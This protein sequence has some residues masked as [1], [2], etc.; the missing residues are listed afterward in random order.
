M[1]ALIISNFSFEYHTFLHHSQTFALTGF[2]VDVFEYHTFLHHSQT[3]AHT[4][5]LFY[6]LSTIHFYII[7]KQFI[8]PVIL[9]RVWVPYIFTSFSNA[10]VCSASSSSFE[11]HTF[12]HHSQTQLL[13][14][15]R[16][17][18]FEY[19]TFLHHSQTGHGNGTLCIRLS[20]IHF[21]IILKHILRTYT[22]LLRLSTIHFYIILKRLLK[23]WM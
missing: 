10:V 3:K 18:L 9:F 8:V 15:W 13:Q 4:H 1:Q 6:R 2:I 5:S 7:L 12:L 20:T 11:Y 14:Y 22:L 21:Y 17:H 16:F 19:H 23:N